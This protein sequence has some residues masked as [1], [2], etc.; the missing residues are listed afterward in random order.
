MHRLGKAYPWQSSQARMGGIR[1]D[2]SLIPNRAPLSSSI[3]T[4]LTLI[5]AI[6]VCQQAKRAEMPF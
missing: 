3:N 2:L 5:A 4:D 1:E 6:V